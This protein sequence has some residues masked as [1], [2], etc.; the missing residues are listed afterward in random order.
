MIWNM[1]EKF[2]SDAKLERSNFQF[3]PSV[4]NIQIEETEFKNADLVHCH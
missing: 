2:C 3:F 4:E 1:N